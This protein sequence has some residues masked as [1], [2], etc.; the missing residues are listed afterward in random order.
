[1]TLQRYDIELGDDGGWNSRLD[2]E[3]SDNGDWVKWED[4]EKLLKRIKIHL[5]TTKLELEQI[6]YSAD[7]GFNLIDDISKR[8]GWDKIPSPREMDEL[9]KEYEKGE[10]E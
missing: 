8:I 3:Q 9:R 10:Q 2:I 7:H 4:V 1:M 6:Q 5:Y